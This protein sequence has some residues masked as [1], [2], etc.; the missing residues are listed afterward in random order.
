VLPG[1]PGIRKSDIAAHGPW[2]STPTPRGEAGSSP[3]PSHSALGPSHPDGT[4]QPSPPFPHQPPFPPQLPS[5]SGTGPQPAVP[6]PILARA[7]LH[8]AQDAGTLA[9]LGADL[10]GELSKS[11]QSPDALVSWVF[12]AS[13]PVYFPLA[14]QFGDGCRT[15]NISHTA[16]LQPVTPRTT[17]GEPQAQA[18]ERFCLMRE[19]LMLSRLFSRELSS[20]G[21]ISASPGR[22]S[23]EWE[24][25]WG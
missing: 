22:K 17:F 14:K 3:N 20:G 11:Q 5:G 18:S 8:R 1:A 10:T 13:L 19:K 7:A 6:T 9:L 4:Q 23:E 16:V 15:W 2:Q 25:R 24:G 21:F 12:F